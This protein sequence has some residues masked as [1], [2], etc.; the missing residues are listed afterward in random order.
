MQS[1]DRPHWVEAI[2][3]E[4]KSL[5][6]H[7]TWTLVELPKGK[8]ALTARWI[9]KVKYDENGNVE[10][11]K[12]RLVIRGYEQEKYVDYEEIF[13]PVLRLDSVRVLLALVAFY[14][15]ECHQMD[16]DTA[17]LNG[18]LEE[19]VYMYQATGLE[20]P[21]KEHL[22]CKL[23]K[24]LYGLK[25][26]PRAWYKRLTNFLQ[27]KGF[28]KC[29][30][31]SCIWTKKIKGETC[32]IG[33]YVDDLMI[34]SKSMSNVNTIKDLL[35]NEFKCK[36]L[37]EIHHLLGL[38]ITRNRKEKKLY[39][40]QENYVKNV[41]AR[42]QMS[43]CNKADTPSDLSQVKKLSK[44]DCPKE[45]EKMPENHHKKYREIVGS[46][47]YLLT[48]T[49]P[50]IAYAVQTVSRF[51]NN[52]GHAH[53][54]AAKRIL[55]YVRGTANY[56]IVYNGRT[57]NENLIAYV[58]SDYAKEPDEKRSTSGYTMMLA[59]GIVTYSSKLQRTTALSSAE[60]EYMALAHGT[61][62][63]IF[64]RELLKEI[65]FAQ[66]P[67]RMNI[68]NQ[69]AEQ[70]ANNPVHHQRT[71]HIDVRYHFV[72]QRVELREIALEHVSTKENLA[73][74]LTK[75]VG[76]VILRYLRPKLGVQGL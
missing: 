8:K 52:P 10:R 47:M 12:A 32:I 28:T 53:M 46:L 5:Q 71:K 41:L 70:M 37:G 42:F 4:G 72:R 13:A 68:D 63:V 39:I 44:E 6:L 26:A 33:I 60:A 66:G 75:A 54:E 61:Q 18:E 36:D 31:D 1:G 56:G 27:E 40:S 49:R 30:V 64:L 7:G 43:G 48:G 29:L 50:D 9:F 57:G 24:A 23:N 55:R 14:D 11:Y 35:K 21:G 73:D 76:K 65:G 20:E 19:E 67:T 16:I 58:D 2:K 38:K 3:A 59:G 62:E 15:L 51:L 45:G 25:Q 34:I 74:L 69:A 22:V 17:F